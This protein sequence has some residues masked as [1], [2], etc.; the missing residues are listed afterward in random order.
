[1][2]PE[3]VLVESRYFRKFNPSLFTI[4]CLKLEF[5]RRWRCHHLNHRH[6]SFDVSHGIQNSSQHDLIVCI[7][8]G[9]DSGALYLLILFASRSSH[10]FLFAHIQTVKLNLILNVP[11]QCNFSTLDTCHLNSWRKRRSSLPNDHH[12]RVHGTLPTSERQ[13][14]DAVVG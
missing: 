1:M 13:N 6:V 9:L 11:L 10:T 8:L 5:R 12:L 7:W 14:S 2:N 3:M 4:N